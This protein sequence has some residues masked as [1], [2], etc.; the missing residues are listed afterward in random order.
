M[1]ALSEPLFSK[2]ARPVWAKQLTRLPSLVLY[3]DFQ[4]SFITKSQKGQP[5]LAAFQQLQR[6][7]FGESIRGVHRGKQYLPL[8]HLGQNVATIFKI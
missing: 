3:A 6:L 8:C 1:N 2:A 7:L 4:L 5:P